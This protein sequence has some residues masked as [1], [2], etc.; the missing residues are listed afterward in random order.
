MSA[1]KRLF[2]LALLFVTAVSHAADPPVKSDGFTYVRSVGEASEY[3]LDAN[4]LRVLLIPQKLAPVVTFMVTYHVGSRNEVTGTTGATHL[5]EHLMFKGTE[6]FDRSKGTG[7]DQELE[8]VGAETNATT[9]FDRTNYFATVPTGALAQLIEI[10]SD[11][12]RNLALREDDRRPEM[13]VV[14]NEFERGE[15]VPYEA[16]T[17]EMRAVAFIAHPYHHDTIGWRSDI[18]RVPIEK[19]RAFYDTFYWPDNATVTVIG[20]FDPA[21]TL[22]LVKKFY[23]VIPKSPHPFPQIYTEEPEQTGQRRVTM[24]RGG[25]IGI[26][27]IAHKIPQ[28][29]HADWPA[30]AVLGSILTEG[31]MSRCYRALTD[32]NLTLDVTSDVAFNHDPSLFAT[33]AMVSPD[34]K[35]EQVEKV[36]VAEIEKLKKS[37]V[38]EAE[39]KTAVAGLIAHHEFLRDG[40]FAQANEINECIAV[41][42]WTLFITLKDKFKTVTAANVQRVAKKYLIE[43]HSTVGWFVPVAEKE[44]ETAEDAAVAKE[45]HFEPKKVL[46]PRTPEKEPEFTAP[47][48]AQ[49]V[50]REKIAGIDV[51]ACPTAVKGIVTLRLSVPAG[52]GAA[53]NRALAHLAAGML[54]RGTKK[55]DQFALADL[56]EKIGAKVESK[57][58]SDAVDFTAKFLAKDLPTVIS[59]LA[60]K[61]RMPAFS[62]SEFAKEKKE[63]A[64]GVQQLL[65]DP[66]QIAAIAFSRAA[67]PKGHPARKSTVEELIASI[68]KTKLDDVRAFYAANYGPEP[69]EK[70]VEPSKPG[71][72]WT[73][74]A[75][76]HLVA[77]GDL[78]PAALKAE[79]S[80]AFDGWKPRPKR[81]QRDLYPEPESSLNV[82]VPLPDKASISVV[83]GQASGVR[84]GE[85]DALALQVATHAL[86]MGFTSR[87]TGNVRDREGLTYGIAAMM[88]DDVY[89]PGAWSV[90]GTFAPSLLDKGLASTR[91]EITKWWNDGL[92]AEELA[93]RKSAIA[94]HYLV[95]LETT[96]GLANQLLL[97]AQRGYD[98]KRVDE[99]PVKI[100]ALTLEQ[101]N[102]VVK[103][104]LDPAKMVTVKAGTMEK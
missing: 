3:K 75:Q 81:S 51:I 82:D 61:L 10:E 71:Q 80:R 69:D 83:I 2:A 37:G 32:K 50:V 14:R 56:L 85:P 21:E 13:T 60:E 47:N 1:M 42:D 35:H 100:K 38:T 72:T 57:V 87:L 39:V 5:L 90:L 34:V 26:V 88:T 31:K 46:P 99:Y 27:S 7:F 8:R 43:N 25:E 16:L 79:V 53:E 40:S 58:G 54:E 98:M 92:S 12:M 94:G 19:L 17:K 68:G 63:L 49:R 89:R 6:K 86:G 65:E 67:F 23:G 52:E 102:S 36:L 44:E 22:G 74:A 20:G 103:K 41:G 28:A 95:S 70:S 29:T 45:E 24:K 48:I 59:V 76:I 64:A 9:W 97:C 33:T 18:E 96:E 4:G 91:R 77:V 15:N 78:D 101:V 55:H 93:Y 62:E 84:S 73:R 11:R 104:H 66:N 30:L